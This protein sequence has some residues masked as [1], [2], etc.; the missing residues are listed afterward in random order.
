MSTKSFKTSTILN[1]LVKGSKFTANQ[2]SPM[3]LGNSA[4][5]LD[6]SD[7][8][9]ISLSS[10][11]VTQWTDKSGNNRNFTQSDDAKRPTYS[12]N[13][14]TLAQETQQH[15]INTSY[16]LT[17]NS[18]SGFVVCQQSYRGGTRNNYGRFMSLYNTS[19]LDYNN[20]NS[21]SLLDITPAPSSYSIYRNSGSIATTSQVNLNTKFILGFTID[22]P[23][24]VLYKNQLAGISGTTS[25][26]SLNVNAVRLGV[27]TAEADSNF[28]GNYYEVIAYNRALTS[29]E[30]SLLTSYLANKWSVS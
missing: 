25:A 27:D 16:T 26:T 24:V 8:S 2:F 19:G 23:N 9:T 12:S 17:S 6:A 28:A 30:A 14:I 3:S 15:L 21:I 20:L 22:G 13:T 7:Q 5:W 10:N 1:G 18:F 11:K 4:W 29:Y